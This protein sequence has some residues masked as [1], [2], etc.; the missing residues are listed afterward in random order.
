MNGGA[1]E[2]GEIREEGDRVGSRAKTKCCLHRSV[3]KVN[4][5][6]R[7]SYCSHLTAP[8]ML[9]RHASNLKRE[10]K[11]EENTINGTQGRFGASLRG[12]AAVEL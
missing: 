2:R 8:S 7:L 5:L 11:N 9:N 3:K 12:I 6:N 4:L 1:R 10:K